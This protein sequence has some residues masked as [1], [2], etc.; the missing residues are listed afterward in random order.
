MPLSDS[1]PE[2]NLNICEAAG[3]EQRKHRNTENLCKGLNELVDFFS[4][5]EGKSIGPND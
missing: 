2:R 1:E 3:N 4:I 5:G